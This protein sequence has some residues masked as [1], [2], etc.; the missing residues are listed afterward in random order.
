MNIP[1]SLQ[2]VL[3]ISGC[4]AAVN[5]SMESAVVY[6]LISSFLLFSLYADMMGKAAENRRSDWYLASLFS[7]GIM[8]FGAI[9]LAAVAYKYL[10]F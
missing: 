9:N 6:A 1:M 3:F 7:D 4:V 8:I 2:C 10:N 5:R